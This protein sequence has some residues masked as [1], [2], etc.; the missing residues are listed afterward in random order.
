MSVG[1]AARPS[2]HPAPRVGAEL[3]ALSTTLICKLPL[4]YIALLDKVPPTTGDEVVAP[5]T[6]HRSPRASTHCWR[7]FVEDEAPRL[8]V[9]SSEDID[10]DGCSRSARVRP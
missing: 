10:H 1:M 4:A 9:E 5:R 7:Q 6:G 3:L 8:I 2:G